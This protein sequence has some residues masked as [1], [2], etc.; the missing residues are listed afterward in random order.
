MVEIFTGR[1]QTRYE[2]KLDTVIIILLSNNAYVKYGILKRAHHREG[3]VMT[4]IEKL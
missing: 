1:I 3:S 2:S 4:D